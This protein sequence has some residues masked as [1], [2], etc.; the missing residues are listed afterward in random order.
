MSY[1][2][3][4]GNL[5]YTRGKDNKI[6]LWKQIYS[7][8]L[9]IGKR[10][11]PVFDVEKNGQD[12]GERLIKIADN[13]FDKEKTLLAKCGIKITSPSD[14][15][16]FVADFNKVL[17][18]VK[19]FEAAIKRI[20]KAAKVKNKEENSTPSVAVNFN[21][22]F[23]KV[24]T[25]E[26]NNFIKD[27]RRR[28]NK[29]FDIWEQ[30]IV[31]II[32]SS[33]KK[34]LELMLTE[35]S[36]EDGY[37]V[38]EQYADF[39][40]NTT[41]FLD[42]FSEVLTSKNQIKQ[43]KNILVQEV[44][45]K[46]LMDLRS[47]RKKELKKI[48]DSEI[49]LNLGN[50]QNNSTKAG[51]IEEFLLGIAQT[52]GDA[53]EEAIK[54]GGS[55]GVSVLK[56]NIL[57]IDRASFLSFNASIDAQQLADSLNK[58]LGSPKNLEDATRKIIDF[59]ENN[60]KNLKDVFAIYGS[61]K[62]YSIYGTQRFEAGRSRRLEELPKML[63]SLGICNYNKALNFIYK[64]YNTATYTIFEGERE[65][66]QEQAKA[67]IMGAAAALLFDDW[68]TIGDEYL[69]RKTNCIH[70]LEL[71]GIEIPLSVFLRALGNAICDA[72]KDLDSLFKVELEVNSIA[73]EKWAKP[74]GK[75]DYMTNGH[76]NMLAA[77]NFQAE[78]ARREALFSIKFLSN[79]KKIIT[80]WVK[81]EI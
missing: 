74:E 9:E 13:E 16:T 32:K 4:E 36:Q 5:I 54:K 17:Q 28:L 62:L 59:Y 56:S 69:K 39:A 12:L 80:Q 77:W 3:L 34:A 50:S 15:K 68:A 33:L 1:S 71:E 6:S 70:V 63:D 75:V 60:L 73:I 8:N 81:M 76:L 72:A 52:M 57:K 66:L 20:E 58:T 53:A 19:N 55:V 30:N 14:I 18:G 42:N 48:L 10:I 23:S 25:E 44:N 38:Y 78:K 49:G 46:R 22:C 65:V 26:I 21:E 67:A 27:N 7:E 64:I 47:N 79:F 11:S 29:S 40:M 61:T 41:S 2:I 37:N 45:G 35:N 43:L 51:N 24:L 31:N